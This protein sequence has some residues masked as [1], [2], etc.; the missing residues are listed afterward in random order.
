MRE[1]G[2][3]RRSV[4]GGRVRSG[5]GISGFVAASKNHVGAV[6]Q[7]E[8]RDAE[9]NGREDETKRRRWDGS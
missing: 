8:G 9:P 1:E 5:S 7:A 3:Q 4:E 2:G 6:V